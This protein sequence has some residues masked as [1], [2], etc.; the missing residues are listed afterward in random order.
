MG[1]LW[2]GNGIGPSIRRKAMFTPV[3]QVLAHARSKDIMHQIHPK[4]VKSAIVKKA[5][6]LILYYII[7]YVMNNIQ[8]AKDTEV[9]VRVVCFVGFGC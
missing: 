4:W 6:H 9:W 3:W 8:K 7:R 1:A 5:Y 2:G